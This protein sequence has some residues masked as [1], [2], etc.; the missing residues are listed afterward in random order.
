MPNIV[1]EIFDKYWTNEQKREQLE[2]I[3]ELLAELDATVESI[4]R[5]VHQLPQRTTVTLVNPTRAILLD[6]D[7]V[8]DRVTTILT[9]GRG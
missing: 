2:A 6:H 5:T 1:F 8:R 9:R 7:Q 3:R 4:D